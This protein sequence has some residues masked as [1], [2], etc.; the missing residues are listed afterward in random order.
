MRGNGRDLGEG[1]GNC[2]P[3]ALP[4][5][6]LILLGTVHGDPQGYERAWRLLSFF[7]PDLITVEISR[8]SVRYRKRQERRW[9]HLLEQALEDLPA[10]ARTHPAI[11]RLAAQVALPFEVRVARDWG[12]RHGTPW[13]P[14]DLGGPSRRHL[15]RYGRELLTPANLRALLGIPDGS[16]KD[17]VATE[18]RRAHQAYQR[19]PWRLLPHAAPETLKRERVLARRLRR[20]ALPGCRLVHLGG[21]EHLV[22]WQDGYGLWHLLMDLKPCR[23]LLKDAD[24]LPAKEISC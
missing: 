18:F 14:L 3:P 20:L 1:R 8:F 15:P 9:Q 24:L 16:L 17:L 12:C 21:W 23:L 10:S 19:S 7:K 11:Q 6:N 2:V 13:R 5:T 4:S 22:P